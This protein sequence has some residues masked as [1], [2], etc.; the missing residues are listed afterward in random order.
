MKTIKSQSFNR[1][2]VARKH[3]SYDLPN[4]PYKF[5]ALEPIIDA[6][7]MR[8]HH[9]KHHATY[10]ENLLNEIENTK[11]ISK[12]PYDLACDLSIV[13]K[14][15]LEK[16]KNNLGGFINHNMFFRMMRKPEKNNKPTGTISE[17]IDDE[18]DS[19][20]NFKNEFMEAAK[21][22]FG[23]GWIWL[24]AKGNKLEICATKNQDNPLMGK[25]YADADGTPILGLDVWE[26]AYY[27]KYQNKRA[28]YVKAWFDLINWDEVE[29]IYETRKIESKLEERQDLISGGKGDKATEEDFDADELAK[30]IKTEMEHT[31]DEDM[32]K[33]IAMD[34]LTEDP[35][36]YTK[37]LKAGL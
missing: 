32:A 7:T 36:Y 26:H 23:S 4:L 10:L 12:D 1:V 2:L 17:L 37:L 15:K 31:D 6:E 3:E 20:K 9:K 8:I 13:P 19:Y 16:V 34:H 29:R 5:N 18:F 33:E 11:L 25:S 35:K 14:N 27:L 21:N 28:D 22:H 24:C 30:G